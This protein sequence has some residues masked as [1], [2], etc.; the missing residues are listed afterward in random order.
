TGA[1]RSFRFPLGYVAILDALRAPFGPEALV[2]GTTV[3]S[4]EWR[5]GEVVVHAAGAKTFSARKLIVTLPLPVLQEGR[6]TFRP[7]LPDKA[8]AQ[9]GRASCRERGA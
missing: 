1:D 6:V 8:R 3:E 9:I 2:L 4:V 5:P 7:A